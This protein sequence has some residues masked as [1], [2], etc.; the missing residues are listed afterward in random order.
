MVK[1]RDLLPDRGVRLAREA[2]GLQRR[3]QVNAL[4]RA[5]RLEREDGLHVGRHLT[6]ALRAMPTHAVV[7]LLV[8]RGRQRMHAGRRGEQLVVRR[9][10]GRGVLK[11]HVAG[12]EARVPG[13]EGG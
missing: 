7:V 1:R 12:V 8:G 10:G 5:E 3:Q 9:Q 11:Q 6:R 2:A 4:R 13:E